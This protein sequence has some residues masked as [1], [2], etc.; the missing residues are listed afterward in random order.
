MKLSQ[1]VFVKDCKH[2]LA[3]L[4]AKCVPSSSSPMIR[5]HLTSFQTIVD[6]LYEA[7]LGVSLLA[8]V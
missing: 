3:L 8:N 1:E 6:N 2:Y 7:R 5:A 4:A